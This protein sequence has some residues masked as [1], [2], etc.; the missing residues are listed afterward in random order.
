MY[1]KRI[2]PAA[3]Q[4]QGKPPVI[5]VFNGIRYRL[6]ITPAGAVWV[7]VVVADDTQPVVQPVKLP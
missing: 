1:Q 7:E 2:H 4:L 5:R 6:E 3:R